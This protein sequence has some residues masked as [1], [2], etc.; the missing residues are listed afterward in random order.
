MAHKA[1]EYVRGDAHTNGIESL[2]II[3]RGYMGTYLKM[4]KA[5]LHRYVN[6]FCGH[7]N[8]RPLDTEA[9]M[10]SVAAGMVGKKLYYDDLTATPDPEAVGE[11]W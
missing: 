3:K 4:S 11:P 10:A 1:R 6:E 2:S 8:I 9:Q 7:H 5:H